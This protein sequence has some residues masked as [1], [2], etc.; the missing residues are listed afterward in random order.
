MSTYEL[1]DESERDELAARVERDYPDMPRVLLPR[2][3]RLIAELELGDSGSG[4]GESY[5]Q[6]LTAAL[7]VAATS[8]ATSYDI[9]AVA[10]ERADHMWPSDALPRD[11]V[12]VVTAAIDVYREQ[13]TA[14]IAV[15]RSRKQTLRVVKRYGR[16]WTMGRDTA[17]DGTA[18]AG[19]AVPYPLEHELERVRNG[20]YGRDGIELS[21]IATAAYQL[22]AVGSEFKSWHELLPARISALLGAEPYNYAAHTTGKY[23]ETNTRPLPAYRSRY[24]TSHRG[25]DADPIERVTATATAL[26]TA[27]DTTAVRTVIP[28]RSVLDERGRLI[29]YRRGHTAV[30]SAAPAYLFVGHTAEERPR[31]KSETRH[32]TKRSDSYDETFVLPAGA[33]VLASLVDIAR[34][35]ERDRAVLWTTADRGLDGTITRGTAGRYAATVTGSAVRARGCRTI[36]A[37]ARQLAPALI[38]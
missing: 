19:P 13:T 6:I 31:V 14:V 37:M 2:A 28:S 18:A 24:R 11:A 1:L 38:E 12:A 35:V 30:K 29:E 21:N 22:P 8:T 10:S 9:G 32:A 33:D 26:V 4:R 16:S 3:V 34:T 25:R 5:E 15:S 36:T 17:A 7:A 23:V 20:P 27:A